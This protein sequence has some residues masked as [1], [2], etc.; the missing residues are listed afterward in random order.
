[1]IHEGLIRLDK[2]NGMRWQ[3]CEK[4]FN[5]LW[6]SLKDLWSTSF[7]TDTANTQGLQRE[8]SVW[9]WSIYKQQVYKSHRHVEVHRKQDELINWVLTPTQPW[10]H[11][12]TVASLYKHTAY[13]HNHPISMSALVPTEFVCEICINFVLGYACRT[14]KF[15]VGMLV[16]SSGI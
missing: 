2:Y 7:G 10:Y 14:A 11:P 1:M 15:C 12:Y 6:N 13:K 3:V 9:W 8:R 16:K 5:K 4:L